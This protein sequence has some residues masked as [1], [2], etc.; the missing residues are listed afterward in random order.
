MAERV[1]L[2]WNQFP[3]SLLFVNFSERISVETSEC[4]ISYFEINM[5]EHKMMQNGL[6]DSRIIP[7][8]INLST[9]LQSLHDFKCVFYHSGLYIEPLYEWCL[10]TFPRPFLSDALTHSSLLPYEV[11]VGL[12]ADT[13]YDG[14]TSRRH[15]TDRHVISTLG[16][17]RGC[18]RQRCINRL[19]DLS[20]ELRLL[21]MVTQRSIPVR[22]H[23][24]TTWQLAIKIRFILTVLS[25]WVI[26][27]C[28]GGDITIP[29]Q[30]NTK[31][32]LEMVTECL[33][34]L[35]NKSQKPIC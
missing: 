22:I 10:D 24:S 5:S 21:K 8:L 2:E 4:K 13:S 27:Y 31:T 9:E 1:K 29:N 17:D 6:L 33:C 14:S 20:R 18:P 15:L 12:C 28:I 7:L 34:D 26:V 16:G 35:C 30:C 11:W 19:S 3:L 32:C 25:V 23:H